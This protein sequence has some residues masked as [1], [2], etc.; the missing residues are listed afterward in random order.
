MS[1][2][3]DQEEV[4]NIT[5]AMRYMES[6]SCIR[7]VEANILTVYYVEIVDEREG[8]NSQIGFV[9]SGRQTLNL[10]RN[11]TKCLLIP[12]VTHELMHTVGFFHEHCA[13]DR[14][15]YITVHLE[16]VMIDKQV[17]F[18]KRNFSHY[19]YGYD[20]GSLMHYG[21]YGFSANGEYTITKKNCTGELG[22]RK[23][24]SNA[25]VLK[26]NAMYKCPKLPDY[27]LTDMVVSIDDFV[28]GILNV[29]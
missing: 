23:G 26:L 2:Q 17:F 6:V 21:P 20:C 7:F 28:S 4:N 14:D 22:Q 13:P 19:G 1:F 8:C 27:T 5:L 18:A 12:T 16:N 3:T 11:R 9:G 15:D 24:L 29:E 25:D 10:N